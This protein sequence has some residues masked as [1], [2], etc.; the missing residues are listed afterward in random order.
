[1]GIQSLLL[2]SDPEVLSVV[3]PA[4]DKL[5][6]QLEIHTAT[7]PACKTLT[8]KKFDAIIIDCADGMGSLDLLKWVRSKTANKNSVSF[9]ILNSDTNMRAAFDMGAS[10]VLQKPV[11]PSGVVR[12]FS[13]AH[14]L[15]VRE[16][17]RYVRHILET[18]VT[19]CFASGKKM[20]ALSTNISERGMA[21][22]LLEALP[23]DPISLLKFM[24]PDDRSPMVAKAQ[25]AWADNLG[26]VGLKFLELAPTSRASLQQWL[27][28][29][30]PAESS[31]M[32]N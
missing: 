2:S 6:V 31:R 5:G 10:F 23:H 17:H 11:S 24:L 4:L 12:S 3:Q 1:M 22:R 18:R 29:R 9:A 15:M 26:R 20:H 28:H 13:A 19:I 30:R 32:G 14:G 25:V 7:D 27:Q 8:A 16:R 21:V